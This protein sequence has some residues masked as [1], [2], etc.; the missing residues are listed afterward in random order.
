VELVNRTPVPA[1]LRVSPIEGK[2]FRAGIVAAKATYRVAP[3]G[4]ELDTQYPLPLFRGDQE[5]EHGCLPGDHLPRRDP[6]FEVIV[7]GAA[8]A[9]RGEP[10]ERMTLALTVGERRREILVFGDRSW[11]ISGEARRISR[12]APFTRMPLV[13]ERAFGGSAEVLVDEESPVDFADP[14][15][16]GGRGFDPGPSAHELCRA[17]RA[18]P[19]Y[20]IFDAV[21]RLPNL[22]SP[23]AP[24]ERWEDAPAPV[25][26]APVPWDS[27]LRREPAAELEALANEGAEPAT[28]E[29][30]PLSA[31]TAAS[32]RPKYHR[33]HPD[34]II[35]RPPPGTR[36][37]LSGMTLDSAPFA[38]QLP[39][40]RVYVDYTTGRYAGT[41]ELAPQVLVLL[42]EE[43]R[44]YVVL[45]HAFTVTPHPDAEQSMRLRVEDRPLNRGREP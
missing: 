1:S 14:R 20:P 4:I 13:W 29:L 43:R 5:T 16:P 33:A 3:S 23:D 42:P 44:F 39:D 30:P 45:R 17:W 31:L 15:N 19:G 21:R 7:V 38:F 18:P 27:A 6:A 32:N 34:W 40:V 41:R 8:H 37:E 26:W 36:V 9:P 24:I 35:D 22:E 11:E 25:C 28:R 12:P 10:V 2:P